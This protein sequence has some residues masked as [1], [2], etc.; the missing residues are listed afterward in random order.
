MAVVVLGIC[1]NCQENGVA[2]L[3]ETHYRLCSDNVAPNQVLECPVD[4]VCTDMAAFCMDKNFVTPSCPDETPNG[5]CE[6]CNGNN[7]F[8]CTSRSTFQMCDGTTLTDQVTRCKD[9]K[10]CSISSGKY[11][12]DSCEIRGSVECDRAAP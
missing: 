4:K 3:N 9:G 11:C 5:A 10:I 1:D 2:C 7:L 8:V 6:S 12:V